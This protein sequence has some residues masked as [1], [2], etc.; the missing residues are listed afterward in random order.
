MGTSSPDPP[1]TLVNGRSQGAAPGCG[2]PRLVGPL[3]AGGHLP[4][5]GRW[6]RGA[7]TRRELAPEAVGTAFVSRGRGPGAPL[8]PP[9]FA[10]G[11][12]GQVQPFSEAPG[13]LSSGIGSRGSRWHRGH[14]VGIVTAWAFPENTASCGGRRAAARGGGDEGPCPGPGGSSSQAPSSHVRRPGG[15]Q[16][17]GGS[18]SGQRSFA[19]AGGT[20]RPCDAHLRCWHGCGARLR[21]AGTGTGACTRLL[22]LPRGKNATLRTA[23]SGCRS[24]RRH[25]ARLCRL[26]GDDRSA[27]SPAPP[28]SS[29]AGCSQG[30][31][32]PGRFHVPAS[33]SRHRR[34]AAQPPGARR[35]RRKAP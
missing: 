17:R 2:G 11:D 1:G 30:L 31:A 13:A 29:R 28:V 14:G 15:S 16:S 23:R 6:P 26:R 12:Q 4:H 8:Q 32:S 18:W 35:G 19:G 27:A 33:C 24:A 22:T 5:G 7:A 10:V 9:P 21:P 20:V 34:V 25:G 3:S